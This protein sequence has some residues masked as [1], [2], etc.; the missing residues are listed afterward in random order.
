MPEIR[1]YSLLWW[2]YGFPAPAEQGKRIFCI[3]TGHF[4]LAF[5]VESVQVKNLGMMDESVAYEQAA[6]QET[7]DILKLPESS[8]DL[9]VTVDG[10]V[11]RCIRQAGQMD[12]ERRK[13]IPYRIIDS[14]RYVQ[15]F[16][17]LDLVFEDANGHRLNADT[18]IELV[19][20]PQ[21]LSIM[22]EVRPKE[23]LPNAGIDIKVKANGLNVAQTPSAQKRLFEKSQVQTAFITLSTECEAVNTCAPENI[24]VEH[25][26]TNMK[27][28]SKQA[29][30]FNCCKVDV[31]MVD[32]KAPENHDYLERV[33][34]KLE[35]PSSKPKLLPLF[36]DANYVTTGS[37]AVLRDS[38]GFPCG[39]PVQISKNWHIRKDVE[40]LYADYWT[41][42][43]TL[44]RIP[45]RSSVAFEYD[46]ITGY[47]GK[48]PAVSHS[49]LCLIGWGGHQLWDQVGIGNWG[50]SICYDPEV[51]LRRSMIDDMRPL[52]VWAKGEGP[53]RKWHWTNNV[54]GA[55]FLVYYDD[56]NNLQPLRG[57]KTSYQWYGPNLAKV[58]YTGKTADG[59]MNVN[60]T[61]LSPRC[62]DLNR[63]YHYIRY[64]VLKPTPF[65]RLAF[66]QLNADRYA[67]LFSEELAIGNT[68]GVIKQ[69]DV[70]R[71]GNRYYHRDIVCEGKSP[72]FSMH[73]TTTITANHGGPLANKGLVIRAWKARFGSKEIRYPTAAVYGT[74]WGKPNAVLEIGP[75][76]D[77]NAL[78]PGDYVEMLVEVMVVP[79]FA[80]DY[81]GPNLNLKKSLQTGEDTYKPILRHAR[82]NCFDVRV[83]KGSLQ[84]AYP[85]VIEVD[86]NQT[87][88]FELTGG[89]AYVPVTFTGLADYKTYRLS[90][91]V[92][93]TK[94]PVDQGRYGNDYWQADYDQQFKRWSITYNIDLDTPDDK[95]A[96]SRWVFEKID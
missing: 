30:F 76:S 72:W 56:Q 23:D 1:D 54:G 35:N 18:R 12:L 33:K 50:E 60:I 11:Y 10:K 94:E 75:P 81:Y 40:I 65:K 95:P 66:Y 96:P 7:A 78:V 59:R 45:A 47:W 13:D 6:L 8:L 79:Q 55:D 38:N 19:A 73:K 90:K 61:V 31:P 28:D 16:D 87:A 17:I 36:F 86:K 37:V 43:Y 85:I 41:H 29:P 9:S 27:L 48:L 57:V 80:E 62:D 64:D 63:S 46:Y 74:S 51:N 69:F 71:G 22:L 3:R 14:G 52:M 20:W 91:I 49:Q 58:T 25:V 2:A 26:K 5:D 88:R 4:G 15:R 39:I 32:F 70:S 53:K 42:A 82:G 93:D 83:S 24:R 89:L 67:D 34:V 21:S 92:D 77:I 44:L 68:E 84:N